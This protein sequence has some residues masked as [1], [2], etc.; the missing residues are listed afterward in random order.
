MARR[1][2]WLGIV[3]AACFVLLFLQLNNIQVVKAHR[4]AT[5][6]NNPQVISARYNQPRG[7]ILSADGVV[8]ARSVQA[9]SGAYK[10]ERQYPEGPVFGQ[11]TGYLSFNYLP[12]GVE[13]TY[14]SYLQA[15]NRPIKTLGDLLTTPTETD[16]V[17]LT[18]SSALQQAAQSALGG[19]NGAIVVLDPTTGAIRAMYS[20]PS[21]DPNPLAKN[22]YALET[23]AFTADNTPDAEG[24]TPA[25]SLAY[26]D[27]FFPGSTFK[28]VTTSAAY[29]YAP[30]LVNTPM[31]GFSVI[32]P[33][34][35]RGQTT[36][37]QNFGAG[38]CG[39]TIA[40]MLPPSCDTG[41]AILGTRIGAAAMLTQADAFGFNQQPPIDLPHSQFEVSDFLQPDCYQ[42]AQVYLAFSSIGQ[43]CTLASPL[44]MAMVAAG[45]ADGGVVM[46][47]HVMYEIRDSQNNLVQRYQP[48]P[49]LRATTPPTA[50]A[51]NHLM[52]EVVKAGTASGVGFPAQDDVA[53]KTG[54]A[55]VGLGN[56][57]TTDWMIAFAPASHP[58][59]AIAVVIPNQ[60]LSATGAEVAGPVMK[61]MIEAALATP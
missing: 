20:N 50:A 58:T 32:P 29:D 45:I 35:F 51:V 19:R 57:A 53:A 31:P 25:T 30:K 12:T 4:Y 28:V 8:L 60:R 22:N 46:T 48:V 52:T 24:F 1:I 34:Y 27:H 54:T 14:G 59:V 38:F 5:N 40:E 33:G 36:P 11:I 3:M 49:W 6:V 21:F 42:N 41:Y 13:D 16:T 26:Q 43:K 7:A 9:T 23:Q 39:G 44:Q 2:R 56:T 15:H 47:P 17:T 10:Y 55:Q 61:A 37:L 18:V